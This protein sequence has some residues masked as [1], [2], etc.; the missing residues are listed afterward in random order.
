MSPSRKKSK[1]KSK[2]GKA[3]SGGGDGGGGRRSGQAESWET[4]TSISDPGS[5]RHV[6]GEG[7]DSGYSHDPRRYSQSQGQGDG[8]LH[9][10]LGCNQGQGPSQSYDHHYNPPNTGLSGPVHMPSMMSE[11]D[12]FSRA[13]RGASFNV[14]NG[15]VNISLNDPGFQPSRQHIQSGGP[16]E[17]HLAGQSMRLAE[18]LRQAILD[19]DLQN[20]Q[21]GK[22]Q[23][24]K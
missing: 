21:Q 20:L 13:L 9:A 5:S 15:N 7:R 6:Q 18:L 8:Y 12:M 14:P 16:R 4:C 11:A 1:S 22:P 23:K 10:A 3:A 2:S 24:S 19:H 17:Q